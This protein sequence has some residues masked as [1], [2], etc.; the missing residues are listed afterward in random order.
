MSDRL[1]GNRADFS[2]EFPSITDAKGVSLNDALLWAARRL[3]ASGSTTPRLDAE[4]LLGHVLGLSRTQLYAHG[5]DLLTARQARQYEGLVRR[6][7]AHE[8]AAYL[9]GQRAFYDLELAVDHRV[10][11]PRPET[12]HLVEEALVWGRSHQPSE[13][14]PLRVV[15]V[16]TGSGALAI[17]LA[18]HLPQAHVWAVDISAKA[19][20]VAACNLRRY[21]LEGR[22]MLLCADLL[23][24]FASAFELI[25]ANLPY[26]GQEELSSLPQDVIDYE[27][28]VALD[29][30]EEGLGVIRRLLAQAP[31][32]LASPGLLLLEIGHGQ[33]AHV[34]EMA[35]FYLPDATVSLLRD[36]AG[37]ERVVRVER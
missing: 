30:G 15:D 23:G 35:H 19:L 33:G 21:S 3:A 18:R 14:R 13:G 29:G 37:L 27:P 26:I 10:L 24:A 5:D 22:V 2:A 6:R 11:I 8:P 9:V 34:L 31:E 7:A 1:L 25:V 4:V 32:R 36:Y 20:E 12:E 17:V 16:G 28:R